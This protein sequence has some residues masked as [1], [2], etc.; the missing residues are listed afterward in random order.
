MSWSDQQTTNETINHQE[1]E[2]L[3]QNY[4]DA[5]LAYQ[6]LK[7]DYNNVLEELSSTKRRMDLLRNRTHETSQK[8]DQL[9]SDVD[10]KTEKI[11]QLIT[12]NQSYFNQLNESSQTLDT[13]VKQLVSDQ[14]ENE[15][16]GIIRMEIFAEYFP[17]ILSLIALA[18]ILYFIFGT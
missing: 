3:R 8:F 5:E 4:A 17:T 15:K 1:L 9:K 16:Q 13:R 11:N 7:R 10:N 2:Q 6:S 18:S 14:L 12:Q